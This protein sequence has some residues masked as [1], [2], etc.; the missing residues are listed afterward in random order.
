[1]N[2]ENQLTPQETE[3]LNDLTLPSVRIHGRIITGLVGHQCSFDYS[4]PAGE[5]GQP[6][7]IL[8]HRRGKMVHGIFPRKG[9]EKDFDMEEL[10]KSDIRL[11]E[12]T[13][14]RATQT[15]FRDVGTEFGFTFVTL[16]TNKKE[17][18]RFLFRAKGGGLFSRPWA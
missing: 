3:E 12:R 4:W 10:T 18:L 15:Y 13:I 2:L 8:F 9:E 14:T 17:V 5:D 7:L 16:V 1:M 11:R 6:G